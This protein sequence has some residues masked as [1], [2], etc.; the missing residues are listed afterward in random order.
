MT[1]SNF[2]RSWR[3]ISEPE[4]LTMTNVDWNQNKFNEAIRTTNLVPIQNFIERDGVNIEYF[5]MG[6]ITPS[7][8]CCALVGCR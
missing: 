8:Y 4:R 1:A 3:R 5:G 2:I 7:Q 6:E